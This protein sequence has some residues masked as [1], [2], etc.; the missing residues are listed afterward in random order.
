[1]TITGFDVLTERSLT[2]SSVNETSAMGVAALHQGIDRISGDIAKLPYSVYANRPDGT[3]EPMPSHPISRLIGKLP[4]AELNLTSYSFWRRTMAEALLWQNSFSLIVRNSLGVPQ[5]IIPLLPG[6][7]TV[8]FDYETGQRYVWTQLYYGDNRD[9]RTVRLN[10]Y[11]VI[12]LEG[13]CWDGCEAPPLVKTARQ[14]F[15]QALAQLG[16][17]TAFFERGGRQAGYLEIPRSIGETARENVVSSFRRQYESATSFFKTIILHD[18]VKFQEGSMSPEQGQ[19]SEAGKSNRRDIASFLNIRPSLIGSDDGGGYN[20]KLDDA[21]DYWDTTLSPWVTQMEAECDQ[22]LL[23]RPAYM[24][25]RLSCRHDRDAFTRES[26]SDRYK[27]HSVGLQFMFL[28]RNEVRKIENLPAV[29][30]GDEF[31]NPNTTAPPEPEPEAESLAV[32]NLQ[33][34]LLRVSWDAKRAAKVGGNRYCQWLDEEMPQR[35]I[36][37]RAALEPFLSVLH[38]GR[39]ASAQERLDCILAGVANRYH[40][41]A[42][43]ATEQELLQAVEGLSHAGDQLQLAAS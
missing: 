33:R 28:T 3:S 34:L 19:A 8:Q 10:L 29:D 7:T 11:D 42:T 16:Y 5:S 37:V 26:R 40:Q 6:I 43:E 4:N 2:S 18:G 23:S 9:A 39:L 41:V 31:E 27:S 25:G 32:E 30:G 35:M 12:W 15:A 24:A 20:S 1:M 13:L 38:P 17:Q 21:R 36:H 14:T 22:K